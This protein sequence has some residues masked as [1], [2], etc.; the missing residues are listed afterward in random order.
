MAAFSAEYSAIPF[1]I[2]EMYRAP[3]PPVGT[4]PAR[5]TSAIC[6]S[7]WEMY[8]PASRMSP[9][10]TIPLSDEPIR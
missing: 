5:Q 7:P 3:S 4:S 6:L 1:P 10:K 2:F 9:T 8:T